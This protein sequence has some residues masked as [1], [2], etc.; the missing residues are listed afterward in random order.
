M[1]TI[2]KKSVKVG[3]FVN[4]EHVDTVI[5]NYKQERWVHNS[6][7][8]GKEDSLSVWHSIEELEEL[9]A[10]AKEHGGD[11][12]RFYFAA[13]PKDYVQPLYA[14]RQTIVMVATKQKETEAGLANKDIYINTGNS[15]EILAFNNGNICPPFCKPKGND[16]SD[17]G[18]T[19]IDKGQ[20]GVI[21]I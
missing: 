15:S 14:G 4:T 3:K 9:L 12:I 20:E 18:I 21:V 6:E 17:I 5:R 2:E 8:L 10:K 13:Y 1:L 16:S 7:R 19:I 11:G